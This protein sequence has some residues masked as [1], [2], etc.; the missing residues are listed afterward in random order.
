MLFIQVGLKCPSQ[1]TPRCPLTARVHCSVLH[2]LNTRCS[3]CT[4]SV[5]TPVR[6]FQPSLSGSVFACLGTLSASVRVPLW[7][8]VIFSR[9]FSLWSPWLGSTACFSSRALPVCV[10][11]CLPARLPF[12]LSVSLSFSDRKRQTRP[13]QPPP[14]APK[15]LRQT[16]RD[17]NPIRLTRFPESPDENTAVGDE[18]VCLSLI[19]C[20][21][22]F[23]CVTKRDRR[24]TALI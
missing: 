7:C 4:L 20:L 22:V 6:S 13:P 11:V 23:L 5:L 17:F 2:R 1:G 16:L 24:E 21:S 3:F 19:F 8:L 12:S 14:P 15:A 18:R 10:C 9:V